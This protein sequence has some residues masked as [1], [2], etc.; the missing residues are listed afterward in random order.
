MPRVS[1]KL[2]RLSILTNAVRFISYTIVIIYLAFRKI[3]RGVFCMRLASAK[4]ALNF[5][6]LDLKT[7][8]ISDRVGRLHQVHPSILEL[9]ERLF[10]R[11]GVIYN[12]RDNHG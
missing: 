5:P 7:R 8:P 12:P 2:S 1:H 11:V 10:R 6:N 3:G 4:N 9:L